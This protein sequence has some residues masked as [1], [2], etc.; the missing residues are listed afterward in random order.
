M[1]SGTVVSFWK[2]VNKVRFPKLK[3]FALK[4]TRYLETQTCVRIHFLRWSRSN[5]KT[6]IKWQTK[7]WM[8]IS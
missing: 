8:I 3:D 7:Y 1:V 6:G 5:L 4:F 2:L